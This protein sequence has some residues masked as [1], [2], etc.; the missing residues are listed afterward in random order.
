MT[1]H[2]RLRSADLDLLEGLPRGRWHLIDPG[3]WTA[4]LAVGPDTPAVRRV[5]P[6]LWRIFTA[7]GPDMP[8]A[9]IEL[10][11]V[12]RQA[13]GGRCPAHTDAE[14]PSTHGRLLAMS[15]GLSARGGYQGG[16]LRVAGE[17][18]RL[19]RGEVVV[20]PAD[21]RHAVTPVTGGVRLSFVA[22]ALAADGHAAGV[23]LWGSDGAVRRC[24]RATEAEIAATRRYTNVR[25]HLERN[26]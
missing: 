16:D 18:Y 23:W 11:A 15:V 24:P 26:T 9:W 17:R 21:A 6:A 7:A 3:H 20:F 25:P 10:S 12:K 8:L 1:H 22:R 5:L 14:Q 19:G 13:N 2:A 4:R